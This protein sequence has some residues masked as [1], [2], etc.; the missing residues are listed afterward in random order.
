VSLFL[1]LPG[2]VICVTPAFVEGDKEMSTCITPSQRDAG[3]F[4]SLEE[5][6]KERVVCE[7]FGQCADGSSNVLKIHTLAFKNEGQAARATSTTTSTLTAL[8]LTAAV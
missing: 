3:V 8:V 6:G 7:H 5:G 1:A 2:H 4:H